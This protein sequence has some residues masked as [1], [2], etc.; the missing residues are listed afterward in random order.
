MPHQHL[1]GH[2]LINIHAESPT[3][4]QFNPPVKNAYGVQYTQINNIRLFEYQGQPM[5][6]GDAEDG[7]PMIAR[8][9]IQMQLKEKYP[10]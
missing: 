6:L 7:T 9:S 10:K 5:A 2:A 4:Q 3:A 1:M 8:R